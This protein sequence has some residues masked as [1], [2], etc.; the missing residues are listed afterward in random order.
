LSSE[1]LTPTSYRILVLVGRGGA[2]PHDLVR[3]GRAGRVF[4]RPADSQFYAEPKRLQTLGYL[5]SRRVPGKTRERTHYELTE[6]GLEALQAWLQEPASSP[7]VATD[8]ID[9]MLAADLVGERRVLASVS[10]MR[11]ETE[12]M[13]AELDRS[14][15]AAEQF[16]HRRKYLLLNYRLARA[17]VEAHLEW[18][19]AV[20]RELD[21][22]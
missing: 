15:A 13:L 6:K 4:Q 18:L 17:V 12:E 8:A 9:R 2:G 22:N 16:P 21:A 3:M 11:V 5:T 14:E 20:E 1:A 7:L 10:G 19:D